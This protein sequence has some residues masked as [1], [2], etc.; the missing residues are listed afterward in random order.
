SDDDML[1][2]RTAVSVLR[3]NRDSQEL[4]IRSARL[5]LSRTKIVAPFDGTVV[6]RA[7]QLG[8]LA[9]PG[10]ALITLVQT[11]DREVD[12]DIDP[13]YADGVRS[14]RELR[15]ESRAHLWPLEVARISP[16]IDAAARTQKGRF[17]FTGDAAAIGTSGEVAWLDASGL[18]PVP[19]IVQRDGKLGVF[20][21]NGNRARFVALPDAQEGRPSATSLPADTLLVVRGQS[22]LQ[23]G[24]ELQITRQ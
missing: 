1:D 5:T 3:A 10:T 7:A 8:S 2:R 12:V 4:A 15:L 20:V 19:L 21:A 22:R 23:D 6:T 9:Q 16:V 17:R 18:L 13:R 24:D 14:A 11:S